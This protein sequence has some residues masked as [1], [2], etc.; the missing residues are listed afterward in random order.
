MKKK[1][2]Y[3]WHKKQ[4]PKKI[5]IDFD[6]CNISSSCDVVYKG[7]LIDT[8]WLLVYFT[9]LGAFYLFE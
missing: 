8:S 2:L 9:I 7:T 6:F 5:S 3:C 1:S 4:I